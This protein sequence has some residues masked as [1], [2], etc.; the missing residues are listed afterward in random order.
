[1]K[2]ETTPANP[3][4]TATRRSTLWL[5]RLRHVPTIDVGTIEEWAAA[6]NVITGVIPEP[7]AA[8]GLVSGGL[9]LLRR[10]R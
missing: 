9:L 5:A 4:T 8:L 10:R 1:M 7:T 2:A 3:S 6:D